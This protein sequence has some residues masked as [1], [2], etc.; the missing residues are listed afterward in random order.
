MS[1]QAR[2]TLV[3][4]LSLLVCVAVLLAT[5]SFATRPVPG[6]HYKDQCRNIAGVQPIYTLTGTGRY[7][8]DTSTKRPHDCVLRVNKG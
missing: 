3:F 7:V 4:V 8:F 2:V 1:M 6:F 5:P